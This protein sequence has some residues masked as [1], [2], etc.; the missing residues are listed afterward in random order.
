MSHCNEACCKLTA[1]LCICFTAVYSNHVKTE[2][3]SQKRLEC[4]AI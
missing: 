2:V 1:Q 3:F 4:N